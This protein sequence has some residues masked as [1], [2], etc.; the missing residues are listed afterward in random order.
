MDLETQPSEAELQ[1]NQTRRYHLS[2]PLRIVTLLAGIGV[3]TLLVTA[4][5]LEP[6]ATG[7]GTHQQ[8]G[9][10]PCTSVALWGIRCPACGM[11]TS[12]AWATRG[13][14]WQSAEANIGGLMLALIAL[15]YV[16]ASCYFFVKGI[17]SYRER[18]SLSLAVAMI[19]ALLA[20]TLQWILRIA[21]IQA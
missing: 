3:L 13:N 16:P 2:W 14:L 21:E 8:L 6:N 10:P 4:R 18:F 9:L 5:Q 11:T 20:A 1:A 12:W 15:A 7:I 19:V 17:A